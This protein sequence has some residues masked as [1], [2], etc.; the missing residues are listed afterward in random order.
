MFDN[1]TICPTATKG[2][3]TKDGFWFLLFLLQL[4]CSQLIL[5]FCVKLFR[6]SSNLNRIQSFN[7]KY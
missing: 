1:L 4:D 6:G 3:Y 5:D 7:K 2:F